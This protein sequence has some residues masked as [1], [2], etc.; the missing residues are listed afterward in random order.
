MGTSRVISSERGRAALLPLRRRRAAG[1]NLLHWVGPPGSQ[2]RRGVGHLLE[3]SPATPGATAA[4]PSAAPRRLPPAL[5]PL[6]PPLGSDRT[7]AALRQRG[8]QG[9]QT[10]SL[11][12]TPGSTLCGLRVAGTAVRLLGARAAA[13]LA[14]GRCPATSRLIA[15]RHPSWGV[16]QRQAAEGCQDRSCVPPAPPA[17]KSLTELLRLSVV[18][19]ERADA[20]LSDLLR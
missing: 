19:A 17:E 15:S 12:P 20:L 18:D 3:P 5:D 11:G 9:V 1:G 14:A 13:A 2:T 10:G 8:L 4:P 7:I 16:A 6:L